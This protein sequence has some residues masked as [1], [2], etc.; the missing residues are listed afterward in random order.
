MSQN[1]NKKA[2][3]PDYLPFVL[4]AALIAVEAI[5]ASALLFPPRI[6]PAIDLTA[7]YQPKPEWY[8]LWIYQ[9]LRYFPGSWAIFGTVLL[10]ALLIL[11]FIFMPYIDSGPRGRKKSLLVGIVL[12]TS[13]AVLT[14][15][16]VLTGR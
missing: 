13:L 14:L 2:F 5:I 7:P 8:F 16:P 1:G 9:L 12:F 15:I 3:Y 11:S 4:V 6:G 10:P